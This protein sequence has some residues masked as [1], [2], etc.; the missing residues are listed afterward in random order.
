[1]KGRILLIGTDLAWCEALTI[2]LRNGDWEVVYGTLKADSQKGGWQVVH[3]AQKP[4]AKNKAANTSGANHKRSRTAT[5]SEAKNELFA[6]AVIAAFGNHSNDSAVAAIN[7]AKVLRGTWKTIPLLFDV[8]VPDYPLTAFTLQAPPARIVSRERSDSIVV[9]LEAL[10]RRQTSSIRHRPP[11]FA[12]FEIS[13][14]IASVSFAATLDSDADT[15][16]PFSLPWIH[17]RRLKEIDEQYKQFRLYNHGKTGRELSADW[18][19]KLKDTGS[20]LCTAIGLDEGAQ[21]AVLAAYVSKLHELRHVHFRFNLPNDGMVHIPFELV[22]D[23]YRAMHLRELAPIARRLVLDDRQIVGKPS[24][25]L[26]RKG[27]YS[28]VLF[29]SSPAHGSLYIQGLRFGESETFKAAK[30]EFIQQELDQL[31]KI[32]ADAKLPEPKEL[33]LSENEKQIDLVLKTLAKKQWDIVHFAGHS[34]CANDGEVFLLLPGP[35][36]PVPL[37]MQDFARAAQEGGA[38]LVVLSSCEGTSPDAVFRLAQAGVAA[39]IGFRWEVE[40][41]EAAE[42]SLYLYEA[43]AANEPIGRAFHHAVKHLKANHIRSPTFASPMLIVQDEVWAKPTASGRRGAKNVVS[44]E[45]QKVIDGES[46]GAG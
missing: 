38:R 46:V 37:R 19:T 30:L 27:S 34:V 5:D 43:L 24:H 2:D 22:W 29:I 26:V 31:K 40:D 14:D 28:K 35:Q 42:F 23:N 4:G 7:A 15:V 10:V 33:L 25:R 32:R 21:A 3:D 16:G 8:S 6:A 13:C 44:R 36:G 9:I 41:A 18:S 39:V 17:N 20:Q 12:A 11:R 45:S 1:M